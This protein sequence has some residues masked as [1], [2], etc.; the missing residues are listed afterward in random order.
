MI[1]Y[2]FLQNYWWFIISLLGGLLVFLLFVQGGQSMIH[3]ISKTEDEK[4]LVVNALGRKWEYTFTT[5]VTFGGAFFAS[6]PL[7]YATSFGGAYWVW[8]LLLFS[9]VVQA[10]SYEFQSKPGNVF[11]PTTY[12]AFLFF[13]GIIGTFVLGVAVAT[14]FTGSEFTINKVNLVSF[15]TPGNV[16]SGW[17]NPLHGLEAL[18]NP[19]NWCL[20]LAVLFL[21]RTMASLFFVNRLDHDVLHARSRKYTLYN[22]V[23]FVVFFLAFL[24]WTLVSEGYAVNPDTGEVFMEPYKYL[25]NFIQMPVVLVLFLLGVVAVLWGI[26]ATVVKRSFNKGIWFAGAGTV[27]AVTMLLLVAG[28]NNTAY[29]PSYTSPQSSLTVQN[30]SS[31]EFTLTAMSIVSLLVPFVLAYIVYAWRALERKKLKLEDL[32]KDGHA[33]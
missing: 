17:D 9:F 26:I 20:G 4:K 18:G 2:E 11:G 3:S 10:V 19:R 21:A 8:M 15:G 1:T 5:L 12:R 25:N 28:Y 30:S 27:V 32:G 29:Y 14:F 33:Y 23:P 24:I 13:N 16:M 31:S 6:F 22:G 7:F